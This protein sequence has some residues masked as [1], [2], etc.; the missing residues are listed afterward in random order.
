[1]IYFKGYATIYFKVEIQCQTDFM[2]C[3]IV[4]QMRNNAEF[5]MGKS[6]HFPRDLRSKLTNRSF[7]IVFQKH[8][9]GLVPSC[10][11]THDTRNKYCS[12]SILSFSSSLH[13]NVC[14]WEQSDFEMEFDVLL[15]E[16]KLFDCVLQFGSV[17]C[18]VTSKNS[19]QMYG[20]TPLS[21]QDPRSHNILWIYPKAHRLY[22]F[23]TFICNI[24]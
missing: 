1:M 3:Y 2:S 18:D 11:F 6:P 10:D 5:S 13:K 14:L 12:S 8:T 20:S 19:Q 17:R 23:D 21:T 4:Q 16:Y 15:H 7:P 9:Q 24:N 22:F